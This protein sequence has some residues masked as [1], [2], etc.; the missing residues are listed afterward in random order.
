V[1]LIFAVIFVIAVTLVPFDM[2]SGSIA[3]P[4]F[5]RG[6]RS[7]GLGLWTTTDIIRNILLFMPVGFGLGER[8][9]PGR[10]RAMSAAWCASW[11]C[12]FSCVVEALQGFIPSRY[13]SALD[14]AA[15]TLG[16]LAGYAGYSLWTYAGLRPAMLLW[17][18]AVVASA[19]PR[20]AD[21]SLRTWDERFPLLVGNELTADRPWA[22]E[23]EWL[24]IGDRAL[25][26][27]EVARTRA[28]ETYAAVIG[29]SVSAWYRFDEGPP[30]RDRTGR[31]PDLAWRGNARPNA[32][33]VAFD[34]GWLESVG[35]ATSLSAR[36]RSTSE[37]TLA[38]RLA[39]HRTRQV[40]PA[41][42]VSLSVNPYQRNLTLG[43]EF[44]N[45][46]VRIRTPATGMNGDGVRLEV[47][48]VFT[49]TDVQDIV[50]TYDGATILA[51]VNGE[52]YGP[53]LPLWIEAP[54]WASRASP[55][56][57]T[58]ARDRVLV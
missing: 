41:R 13:P 44:S 16:A 35:P 17:G 18:A 38:I 10:G 31:G 45:L 3:Q 50:V 26:P 54:R 24:L 43:Q 55:G 28:G 33:G 6:G 57:G 22:G 49:R 1:I 14:V 12:G 21:T 7:V 52:R 29:A 39:T 40:G 15:N 20:P 37:F 25:M 30:F 51:Y 27:T 58:D 36:L 4:A 11:A 32:T 46:I 23:V 47:P 9:P 42:I 48:R 2:L 19:L 5:S 8:R 56:G 34:A 53:A